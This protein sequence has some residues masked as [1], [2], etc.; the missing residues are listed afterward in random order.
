[1]YIAVRWPNRCSAIIRSLSVF[2]PLVRSYP[3]R[4]KIYSLYEKGCTITCEV[5]SYFLSR[6]EARGICSPFR[7]AQGYY[8]FPVKF[9]RDSAVLGQCENGGEKTMSESCVFLQKPLGEPRYSSQTNSSTPHAD[10]TRRK[11]SHGMG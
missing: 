3:S 6:N 4:R 7:Y 11:P 2:A 9:N 5:L 10:A 8:P 1:M